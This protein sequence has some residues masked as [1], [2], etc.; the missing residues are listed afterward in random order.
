MVAVALFAGIGAIVAGGATYALLAA[1]FG[2]GRGLT[3]WA[4]VTALFQDLIEPTP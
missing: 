4:T 3:V 1:V 2:S